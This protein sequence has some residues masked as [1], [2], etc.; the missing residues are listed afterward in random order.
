M[1]FKAD[2]VLCLT[3][4]NAVS[5]KRKDRDSAEASNEAP[6]SKKITQ[7][8]NTYMPAEFTLKVSHHLVKTSSYESQ[9]KTRQ[10]GEQ[11]E[12]L[13]HFRSDMEAWQALSLKSK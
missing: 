11:Q 3:D 12:W 8:V 10:K 4:A 6:L 1:R 5:S 2:A 9:K 13:Q 7:N